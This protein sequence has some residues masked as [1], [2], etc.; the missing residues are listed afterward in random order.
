MWH[1]HAV[2]QG[3]NPEKRQRL[4]TEGGGG[5]V[6]NIYHV[7]KRGLRSVFSI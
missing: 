5:D 1:K 4:E 6:T 3:N 7:M 2:N